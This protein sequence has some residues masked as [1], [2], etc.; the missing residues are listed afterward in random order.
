MNIAKPWY[1]NLFWFW[2]YLVTQEGGVLKI[3][4]ERKVNDK[5]GT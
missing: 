5:G 1:S 4:S 3:R 2:S